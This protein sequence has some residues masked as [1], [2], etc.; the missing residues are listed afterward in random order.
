MVLAVVL[1][2][3]LLSAVAVFAATAADVVIAVVAGEAAGAAVSVVASA[4]VAQAAGVEAAEA[5]AEAVQAAGDSGSIRI[6]PAPPA[7]RVRTQKLFEE[8]G[9]RFNCSVFECTNVD[10]VVDDDLLC[11]VHAIRHW[12]C[13]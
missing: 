9:I 1:A 12:T 4:A 8:V 11:N 7:L 3:E 2:A 13:T 5:S 10:V 6:A